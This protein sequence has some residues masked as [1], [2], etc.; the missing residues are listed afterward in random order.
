MPATWKRLAGPVVATLALYSAL[1]ALYVVKHGGHISSLVCAGRNRAGRPPYEA[2]AAPGGPNGYDGQFYYA[3]ARGP[4]RAH[5]N[6]LIDDPPAR[7]SRILYP[8]LCWLLS[9][10]D[11]H[12]LFWVMPLV[13]LLMLGGLAAV[14]SWFALWHG[15]SAWWGFTLPVALNAGLAALRN[16]TDPTATLAVCGL[17]A[18][19]LTAG[20]RWLLTLCA[21]AALLA[22]EQN[23]VIVAILLAAGLWRG[24]YREVAA[25]LPALGVW[26]IWVS[27]LHSLYGVWPFLSGPGVFGLPLAGMA[28][29]WAHPGGNDYFSRRRSLILTSSMGQLTF[30]IGLA[31]H[32]AAR[33]TD[34]VVALCML[35]GVGLAVLAGV[36]FYCD[37]WSYTRVFVWI[38]LGVWVLSLR[39]RLTWPLAGLA[40]SLLWTVVAALRFI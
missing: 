26:G 38:P 36:G 8:A 25:L 15:R 20:P 40:P 31:L 19:W 7:H 29:R 1:M 34:R 9:G 6:E 11:R 14:G 4:W 21:G 22:R 37:F 23:L 28:Y 17:L 5:H 3:I 12:A 24:R 2:I 13:N 16:L 35:A 33:G 10:G 39:R 27:I 18:V 32:L 30:L